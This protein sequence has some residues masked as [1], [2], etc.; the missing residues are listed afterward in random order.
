M[1]GSKIG[2][3]SRRGKEGVPQ[4]SKENRARGELICLFFAITMPH[5]VRSP[6]LQNHEYR[7]AISVTVRQGSNYPHCTGE[8][9]SERCLYRTV[10]LKI[11]LCLLCLCESPPGGRS[12]RESHSQ[13]G[14]QARSSQD[15]WAPQPRGNLVRLSRP[16]PAP[17]S[18]GPHPPGAAPQVILTRT[19][20]RPPNAAQRDGS[21]RRELGCRGDI[22][23]LRSFPNA[24]SLSR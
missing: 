6:R 18:P 1:P 7:I 16:H 14:V 19:D 24:S 12:G 15:W 21:T 9:A 13:F 2:C 10:L 8:R 23:C 11:R 5:V 3:G 4:H 20:S 22:T 17:R